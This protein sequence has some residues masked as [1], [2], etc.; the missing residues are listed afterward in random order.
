[1]GITI[2]PVFNR[3]LLKNKS[4][5]FTISIRVTIDRRTEYFNPKLPKIEAKYW[6]GKQNKWVKESHPSSYEIN[7]LLQ[8]KLAELDKYI[9]RLKLQEVEVTHDLVKDFYFMKG[10]GTILNEFIED[11]I[12]QIREL[13]P[14][15]VKAY[16]TFQKHLNAFN[17]KISFSVLNEKFLLD[18][19]RYLEGDKGLGGAAVKKYFDKFKVIC[20]EAVKKNLVEA[21]KNPFYNADLKIRVEKPKRTY[22]ELN[23][24][25]GIRQA[26][27]K[28][29]HLSEIRDLFM[30]QI[31]SGMYLSD[32]RKLKKENLLNSNLGCYIL[33]DRSKNRNQMIVPLYKFPYAL[34]VIE[35]FKDE[36]SEYVFPNIISDQ[37]YNRELKVLSEKLKLTKIL[38]NKVGR[39]TNAQ[40]WMGLGV[41]RQFV[42]KMLGHTNEAT[43]QHYYD[44]SIHNIDAKLKDVNFEN[45]GI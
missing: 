1:M 31:Y 38:T 15:T 40:L 28:D 5:L 35:R 10:N 2:A 29:Q 43:T 3:K 39:H 41:E 44:V 23:E 9:I 26:R 16:K 36:S 12:G 11:Y 13:H 25:K 7:S 32:L 34:E 30:F 33:D 19:K 27:L 18:F 14:N 4:G 37:H 22:L 21:T 45:F 17:P 20:K 24:I 42:S 6:G 8:R